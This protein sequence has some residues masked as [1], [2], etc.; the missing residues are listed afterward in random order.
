MSKPTDIDPEATRL[1]EEADWPWSDAEKAFVEARAPQKEA[2][3]QYRSRFKAKVTYE[4]LR[5]RGLVGSAS[6]RE[7]EAGFE[8][9]RERLLV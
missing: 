9:L 8:W 2:T 1:L 7:R 3:E 6:R 5:D 4:D